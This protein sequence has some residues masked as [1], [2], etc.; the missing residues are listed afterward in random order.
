MNVNKK[1]AIHD[2]NIRT[3]TSKLKTK[4]PPST[5]TMLAYTN[6]C[7]FLADYGLDIAGKNLDNNPCTPRV[8]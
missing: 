2:K 3:A 4:S 5:L 6:C 1:T 8:G 7:F